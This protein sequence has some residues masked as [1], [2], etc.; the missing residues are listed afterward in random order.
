MQLKMGIL[1]NLFVGF[2]LHSL[3]PIN[4]NRCK[5]INFQ[6]QNYSYLSTAYLNENICS[7]FTKLFNNITK[8]Y[9][10]IK[11][12]RTKKYLMNC[13]QNS[14]THTG[15]NQKLRHWNYV[16]VRIFCITF[17]WRRDL[18]GLKQYGGLL[19][20]VL[21]GSWKMIR[22]RAANYSLGINKDWEDILLTYFLKKHYLNWCKFYTSLKPE[23]DAPIHRGCTVG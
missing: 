8:L 3:S 23:M 9:L 10:F 15:S 20:S 19:P 2:I 4:S 1:L 18:N 7:K 14:R 11:H 5:I 16:I 22:A 12:T 6:C 17:R 21:N 13:F